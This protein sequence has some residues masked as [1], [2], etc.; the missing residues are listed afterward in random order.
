MSLSLS[1][2]IA[3]LHAP[4]PTGVCARVGN[5]WHVMYLCE[6]SQCLTVLASHTLYVLMER[7]TQNRRPEN[8]D[9]ETKSCLKPCSTLN[10]AAPLPLRAAIRQTES[11]PSLMGLVASWPLA[12]AP[13]L[14][15]AGHGQ[16]ALPRPIHESNPC[17]P[18]CNGRP[19]WLPRQSIESLRALCCRYAIPSIT[20]LTA[21]TWPAIG[22]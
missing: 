12:C 21:A 20:R 3:R 1:H 7:R 4:D 13:A 11:I 17:Y 9:P 15:S 8:N 18:S 10:M 14:P 5:G 6:Y 19:G 16:E 2:A 22:S